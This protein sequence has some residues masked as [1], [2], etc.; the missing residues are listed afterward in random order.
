MIQKNSQP[1]HKTA[2]ARSINLQLT[3]RI[4][5][6]H[7]SQFQHH[8]SPSTSLQFQ[9]QASIQLTSHLP[10][11][12]PRNVNRTC[13]MPIT[14]GRRSSQ[15]NNA[16]KPRLQ[17][18][19]LAITTTPLIAVPHSR[20]TSELGIG[21]VPHPFTTPPRKWGVRL[22]RLNFHANVYI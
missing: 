7:P 18:N 20:L 15:A 17:H 19:A 16:L 4:P 5:E 21:P 3:P 2:T 13:G 1:P 6:P 9:G 8:Y 14:Q 12:Y 11:R 10:M 22:S